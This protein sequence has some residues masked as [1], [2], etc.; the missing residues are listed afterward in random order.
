MPVPRGRVRR[1]SAA[2][3][4]HLQRRATAALVAQGLTAG[5]SLVLQVLAARQLGAAGLGAFTLLLAV[6]L[7]FTT[8]STGWVGDSLTVLDRGARHVRGAIAWSLLAFC[9]LGAAGGAGLALATG[10]ARPLGAALFAVMTTLWLLEDTARRLLMAR[11]DFWKLVVNDTVY[12]VV[13]V[14]AVLAALLTGVELTLE[15]FIAAMAAGAGAAV[16]VAVVQLPREELRGGPLRRQGVVELVRFAGWRSAHTGLQPLIVFLVRLIVANVAGAAA[17]GQLQAA[18]LLIAPV[19]TVRNGFGTLLLPTYT[20]MA[21][22]GEALRVGTH[23]RGLALFA[24]AYGA[25][26]VIWREPLGDL[27]TGG[28]YAITTVA[29]IGYALTALAGCAFLPIGQ[30]VL[31]RQ[32]SRPLFIAR[33]VEAVIAVGLALVLGLGPGPDWVPYGEAAGLTISVAII[34]R[35]AR[36]MGG[37]KPGSAAAP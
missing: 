14:G 30:S 18:R 6:L 12:A 25:A 20:R 23:V 29:V 7:L 17:L 21:R 33:L 16:M 27:L 24:A 3:R 11:L 22:A 28:D 4:A 5:S 36:R 8:L 35:A 19:L 9:V 34:L 37:P 2:L 10:T 32:G 1:L 31:A 15:W 13:A 26:V